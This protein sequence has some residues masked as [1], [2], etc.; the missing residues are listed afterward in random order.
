MELWIFI[1]LFLAIFVVA[2]AISV[3]LD[4]KR[5]DAIKALADDMGF[6][7]QTEPRTYLPSQIWQF[8]LFDKGRSRKLKNLIQ[9]RQ[10][11]IK[12]S[13]GDYQYT[14]GSGKNR[15]TYN[16]TVAFIEADDLHLPS[17][18]LVPEHIFHKIGNLFGYHDID[19]ETHPDF[20]SR[21]LLKGS[22]ETKIRDL[23]HDGVLKFY[24][25]QSRVSTE[26]IGTVFIYYRANQR[27]APERWKSLMDEALEAHRHLST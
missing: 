2:I 12:V 16:Q 6:Q 10:D 27:L 14:S 4:R 19:F 5:T 15:H 26:G 3:Y 20:S 18:M 8:D 23:F 22:D 1:V 9:G 17:F 11:R 13:I 7:F 21:Y 24:Q 25:N